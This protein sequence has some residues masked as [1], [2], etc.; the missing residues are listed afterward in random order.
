MARDRAQV[1]V[2][3]ATSSYY[4]FIWG[5]TFGVVTLLC[6]PL[7]AFGAILLGLTKTVHD[8]ARR[9]FTDP[10]AAWQHRQVEQQASL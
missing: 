8:I 4:S 1:A 5:L 9:S 10:H 7:I 2:Q 6:A 3:K